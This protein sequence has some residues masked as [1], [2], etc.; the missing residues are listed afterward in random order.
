MAGQAVEKTLFALGQDARAKF[1][2]TLK[3]V[4]ESSGVV[5]VRVDTALLRSEYEIFLQWAT[6]VRLFREDHMSLD[7]HFQDSEDGPCI[8][9]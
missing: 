8:R 4:D 7:Y 3:A 1:L 9:S 5:K 6:N 2:T